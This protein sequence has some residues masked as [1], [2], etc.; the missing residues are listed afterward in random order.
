MDLQLDPD[1]AKLQLNDPTLDRIISA[2]GK[3]SRVPD[4][5]AL[6]R[7]LLFLLRPVFHTVQLRHRWL[8]QN[9]N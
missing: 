3:A 1:A 4:R 6:R 2:V 5:D 7:D 8:Q 9:S